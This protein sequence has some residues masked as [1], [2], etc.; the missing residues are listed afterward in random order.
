LTASIPR[1]VP[2]FTQLDSDRTGPATH[3]S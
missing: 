3:A 2:D 1:L